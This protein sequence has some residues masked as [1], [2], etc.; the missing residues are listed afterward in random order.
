MRSKYFSRSALGTSVRWM[1]SALDI[2]DR[3]IRVA[4]E[5]LLEV[6]KELVSVGA[7]DDPMIE[8]E[9]EIGARADGDRIFAVRAGDHLGT[10]LDRSEA[11]D[12]GGAQWNDRRAHER[13]EH[14]GVGDGERRALHFF[15]LESLRS[16]AFGQIVERLGQPG[17]R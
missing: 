3:H 14:T 7:I 2:S 16:G 9:R 13:A 12:R 8:R 15:G 6:C 17:Q 5:V 10:F 11:Q 1:V 4:L